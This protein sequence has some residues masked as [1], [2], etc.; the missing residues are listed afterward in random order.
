MDRARER[1]FVAVDP[2]T[3]TLHV[4]VVLPN[5]DLRIKPAMFGSIRLVRSTAQG[6]VVPATAVV[7]EGNDA[8]VFVAQ[9]N[10]RF[11]RR[12]VKLGRSGGRNAGDCLGAEC[13]RTI[14]SE[15]ALFLR[16]A[17]SGKLKMRGADRIA[18]AIPS[19]GDG[20]AGGLDCGGHLH[21]SR[22]WISRRIP[23][24]RRRWWK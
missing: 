15:G 8:Y 7:R 24:R 4:R 9:G 12:D 22:A 17:C 11:E 16:A 3:R 10:G 1:G 18:A 14:V 20:G 6:I 2:A 19:A 13:R 5:A 21:V 23:I